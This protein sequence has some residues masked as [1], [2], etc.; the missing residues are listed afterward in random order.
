MKGCMRW[1]L[2]GLRLRSVGR[3]GVG[4]GIRDIDRI[5]E[6]GCSEICA[7]DF[8]FILS[9]RAS[10]RVTPIR[11]CPRASGQCNGEEGLKV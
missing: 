2:T 1:S 5:A 3:V 11:F 8:S 10:P 6:I 9:D 7:Q 4:V